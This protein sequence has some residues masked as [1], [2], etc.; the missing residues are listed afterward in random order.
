MPSERPD[1]NGERLRHP[2][3]RK[4]Y[5]IDLG[6]K[7]YIPDPATYKGLFQNE[8]G[9]HDDP[10]AGGATYVPDSDRDGIIDALD[11]CPHDANS[12]QA[13]ADGDGVG[14][15]C[16]NCPNDFNAFQ[17]P[18]C[19]SGGSSTALTL[20]RVRLMAAPNGTIRIRGVLDTTQYGGLD[21]FVRALRTG[22]PADAS[23]ASVNFRQG[24]VFAFNVSGAGLVAPGQSMWF[25]A[26]ASVVGCV[27]TNWETVSFWRKGA[28]N[29]F[30]VDLW[31]N[32]KTFAP[33]LS[34]GPVT[35]TLALGGFDDVDQANCRA[36]GRGK[37][38]SCR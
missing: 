2:V 29:R 31:A 35:V 16:D 26:C 32:S 23:T 4:I 24:S 38:A 15:A 37:S 27:G 36:L 8:D 13:D 7:R 17:T 33:P 20:K 12:D 5:L 18:V 10:P 6:R 28:T 21:G 19:T 22:L 34:S 14:D 9:V 3:D 25:P 1:L 30:T 11:N